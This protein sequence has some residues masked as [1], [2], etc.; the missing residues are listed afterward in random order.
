MA[1]LFYS[2]GLRREKRPI[3]SHFSCKKKILLCISKHFIPHSSIL[4]KIC[5]VGALSI[6]F[7]KIEDWHHFSYPLLVFL[8]AFYFQFLPSTFQC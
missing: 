2:L 8:T 4:K 1:F 5:Q 7:T 6:K 3:M